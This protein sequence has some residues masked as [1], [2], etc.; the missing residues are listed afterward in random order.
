MKNFRLLL[1]LFISTSFLFISCGENKT[2]DKTKTIDGVYTSIGYGHLVKIE[3]GNYLVADIT[4]ISCIPLMSG[5]V[6]EFGDSLK[7]KNDTLSYQ[8]GI[9]TYY[10]TRIED[11]PA[12]CKSEL[13]EEKKMDPEYN[14]EVLWENFKDHYA[15]FELRKVNPEETYA[16]YR[17]R[18]SNETTQAELFVVSSEMLESFH[19]GHISISAS[20]EVEKAAAKMKSE[21]TSEATE[22]EK[23]ELTKPRL[24]KWEVSEKVAEKYIPEGTSIKNGNLRW[25]ILKDNVGYLQLNQM[26]CLSDYN[27]SD[28]LSYRDYWMAYMEI[29]DESA[30]DNEDEI[31]GTISSMDIIMNEL[32]NTAAMIIDVRFNGGGKDEVGMEVLKRFNETEKVVFTKK[33]KLD[34]GFTAVNKVIQPASQK[35]YKKPVY[36]LISVESASATEIMA[37]SALSMPNVTQIGSNTE[38]VFSDVLDKVLPNGWEFGLSSEVYLDLNEINYESI[39]IPPDVEIGYPRDPQEFLYK[40]IDDLDSGDLAIEKALSMFTN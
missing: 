4:S 19:D 15:Y 9:N 28:T 1:T 38:G 37:L 36:L 22:N 17:A 34:E 25:G 20:E 3:S 13:S 12:I 39:G 31:A 27:L 35:P 10:F 7:L 26:M 33:G 24:R 16:K 23:N 21:I 30:N 14:F 29:A 8:D 2:T 6:S 32:G 40:V 18:V 11:S 5:D